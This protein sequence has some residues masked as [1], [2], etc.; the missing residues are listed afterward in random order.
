MAKLKCPTEGCAA[1]NADDAYFNVTVTVDEDGDITE[2]LRK[3]PPEYFECVHCG[4]KAGEDAAAD[5]T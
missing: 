1:Q 4:A 3:I 2:D 5:G